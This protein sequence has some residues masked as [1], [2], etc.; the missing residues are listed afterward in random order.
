MHELAE[1]VLETA[2][3]ICYVNQQQQAENVSIQL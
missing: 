1:S 3:S 2:P